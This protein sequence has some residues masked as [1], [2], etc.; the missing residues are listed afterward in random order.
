VRPGPPLA[1]IPSRAGGG[2]GDGVVSR[3]LCPSCWPGDGGVIRVHAGP[4]PRAVLLP[5]AGS[6]ARRP[7]RVG[8]GLTIKFLAGMKHFVT[9]MLMFL[10]VVHSNC[11]STF[12]PPFQR[13]SILRKTR[14]EVFAAVSRS[15][16]RFR[17]SSDQQC[18]SA[19]PSGKWRGF[20]YW[21]RIC[22]IEL[23][24]GACIF[25][26]HTIG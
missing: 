10:C 8:P 11:F 17:S 9:L 21:R 16:P 3:R 7:L 12:A 18:C 15:S 19:S 22:V 14:T 20:D 2:P 23:F 1:C 5:T 4:G 26:I 25:C 6:R 13:E 24:N